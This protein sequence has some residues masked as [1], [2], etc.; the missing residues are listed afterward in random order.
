MDRARDLPAIADRMVALHA[1][2]RDRAVA[3]VR[4]AIDLDDETIRRL[5]TALSRA[6]GKRVEVKA[7]VDPAVIGGVVARIGETV[8]DGTVR[9]RLDSIRNTLE[10]AARG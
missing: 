7:V 9:S 6:T 10:A 4:T 5:E 2:G 8:I 1:A 3:E